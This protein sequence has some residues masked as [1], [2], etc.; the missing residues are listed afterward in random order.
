MD[1]GGDGQ[2]GSYA[3]TNRSDAELARLRD[4]F[5]R[6]HVVRIRSLIGPVLLEELRLLVR[7]A[8]FA[9]RDDNGIARESRMSAPDILARLVF[10][11]NDPRL[12]EFVRTVT[13]AH[14]IDGFYGRV[15][16][17]GSEGAHFDSWHDDVGGGRR[18]AMS[19]NLGDDAIAGG[20]L[21]LRAK[22][23]DATTSYEY[24]DPGDAL[25]FRI[26]EKLEHEVQAVRSASPR[27]AFAGW[28]VAGASLRDLL[29]Q[30]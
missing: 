1:R 22:G 25:L 8:R 27:T 10:L 19:L 21:R 6:K 26:D 24:G 4:A 7:A 14:D 5:A 15:Y 23:G 28:Y 11:A 12:I 9:E 18:A 13:G 20:E 3:V 29:V 30:A 16:R 2:H 17:F